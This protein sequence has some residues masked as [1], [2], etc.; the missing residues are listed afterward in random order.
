M[1]TNIITLNNMWSRIKSFATDLLKILSGYVSD[2]N[3]LILNIM[4]VLLKA[5]TKKFLI[6]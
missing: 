3:H 1:I 5:E 4:K 2:T 6:Y